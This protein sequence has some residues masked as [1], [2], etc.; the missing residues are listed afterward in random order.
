[1][2]DE[3]IF[4][5]INFALVERYRQRCRRDAHPTAAIM[6]SQSVKTTEAGGP[7]G[8]DGGQKIKGRKP[9]NLVD[10][11]G[12]RLFSEAHAADIQGRDSGG[13]VIEVARR[14]YPFISKVYASVEIV[15]KIADQVGFVVLPLRWGVERIRLAR[16]M[17]QA[18][19]GLGGHNR[20]RE[21]PPLRR[22]RHTDGQTARTT[23]MRCT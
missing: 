2:R 16:K 9:S 1:M 19:K 10:T 8:Y 7:C 23:I 4:E 21:S 13:P 11:G 17:S 18:G 14:F 3:A 15:R 6:D 5:K 12:R 22:R 20:K